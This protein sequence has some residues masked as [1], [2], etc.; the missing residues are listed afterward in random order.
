MRQTVAKYIR[1]CD[2]CAHTKP[3]RHAPYSL[4]KTL[5]V[6][7]QRWSSVSLDFITGLPM[8]NGF[9]ALLVV[10]D[11]LSKMAHYIPT[12]SDVNSKQ[13]AKLFFDN[14]FRLHGIPD[15]IVS[16]RG[17]QFTSDFTRA[18]AALV[19]IH[20]KLSTSFHP[21]TDGQT[22]RVNA[23]VEQYLRGYCNYQQDNWVELLT[24]A[25]FSYNNTM[26][27]STSLTSFFAMY[28]EHPRYQVFPNPEIKLPPPAELKQFANTLES[29]NEYLR[30]EMSWAQA[31]Y[32]EQANKH[33]VPAP[34]F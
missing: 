25:E 15:S 2:T 18:L 24:M 29:L 22:E 14:I 6:P 11:R 17:T 12:T 23:L 33:Q 20:Q 7:F 1:N 28:G 16:D 8:S 10:V 32:S 27:S 3:V 13:L 21:Q 9:D 30:N 5:Q 31:V 26:C 34:R 19:G 4:L